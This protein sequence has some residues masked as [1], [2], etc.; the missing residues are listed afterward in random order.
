MNAIIRIYEDDDWIIDKIGDNIRI[1][2]FKDGHFVDEKI[3]TKQDF[4]NNEEM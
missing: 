2:Y 4:E 3:F 1:S